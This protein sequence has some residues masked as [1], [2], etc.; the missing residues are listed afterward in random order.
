VSS[1]CFRVFTLSVKIILDT[2][3]VEK[4]RTRVLQKVQLYTNTVTKITATLQTQTLHQKR[5]SQILEW[6]WPESKAVLT[7]KPLSQVDETCEW[8][9][10]SEAYKN[11]IGQGPSV[12]ICTGKRMSV[13]M[14]PLTL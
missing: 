12:L 9:V 13:C 11:W 6:I 4:A 8:F 10:R 1:L 14:I 3:D 5:E 7:P 2:P